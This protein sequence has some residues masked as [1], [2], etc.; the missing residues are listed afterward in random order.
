MVSAI[1][2]TY[3]RDLRTLRRAINS[4]INQTYKDL[5]LIV[6]D[7]S[8]AS[9]E[10]RTEIR[11]Y[12]NSITEIPVT[13]IQHERN[14]GA[15]VARNTGID[16]AKGE[17]IAFLDDDDEWLPNKIEKQI[18]HFRDGVGMVYCGSQTMNDDTGYVQIRE[19]SFQ[20]GNVFDTLILGNYIGSTSFPLLRKDI[21][22]EIGKFDPEMKSAQDYDVWLR[23]ARKYNIEY[24]EEPLVLYHV[25][26]GEQISKNAGYIIRGLERIIKK[27]MDYLQDHRDVLGLRILKITP[28]YAKENKGKALRMWLKGAGMRPLCLIDNL[29][30]LA[31]I[32]R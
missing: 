6:V 29:R 21:L 22:L 13:Y 5:E 10:K 14:M 20:S 31:H 30:Y 15:C 27:N 26:D 17:Y 11:E 25:H 16:H 3:K 28:Y 4:V 9:Y 18:V 23:I 32:F 1:I 7:D 19:T 24:T 8:P 2:T 12:V